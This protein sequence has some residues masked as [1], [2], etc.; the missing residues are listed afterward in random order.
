MGIVLLPSLSKAIKNNN[1]KE[2]Q[3]TQNRSLEF[4]HY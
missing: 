4:S 3:N 1:K 2:I